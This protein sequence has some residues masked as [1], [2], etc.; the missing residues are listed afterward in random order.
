MTEVNGYAL[1]LTILLAIVALSFVIFISIRSKQQTE[2]RKALIEKFG[3]T[4]GL[5]ELLQTSE[6]K[7]LLADLS[8]GEATPVRSVL[9]S[10]HKGIIGLGLGL[11]AV[12]VGILVL[13]CV[14]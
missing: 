2:I 10:I 6:G 11:G 3:S 7:H 1:I 14:N 4:Q 9:R 5:V 13:N 12:F 8:T